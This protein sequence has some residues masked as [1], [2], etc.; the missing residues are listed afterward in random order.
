ME[1]TQDPA[2]TQPKVDQEETKSVVTDASDASGADKKG[3]KQDREKKKQERLAARQKK[4][5]DEQDLVKDPSDPSAH[6]FGE[7]ELNRS[8]SDPEK[9]YARKFT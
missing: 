6:L 9:R 2:T 1:S 3:S 4:A 7:L 5:A 8:Q